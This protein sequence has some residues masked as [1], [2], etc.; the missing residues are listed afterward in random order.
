M[1]WISRVKL[2]ALPMAFLSG[3]ASKIIFE[4]VISSLML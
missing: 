1:S 4:K 3:V 2:K